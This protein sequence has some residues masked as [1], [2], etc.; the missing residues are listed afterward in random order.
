MSLRSIKQ[1]LKIKGI[2]YQLVPVWQWKI[3]DQEYAELKQEIEVSSNNKYMGVNSELSAAFLVWCS[4]TFRRVFQSSDDCAGIFK[5]EFKNLPWSWELMIPEG[6][7]HLNREPF[8][9]SDKYHTRIKAEAGITIHD[10]EVKAGELNT[11]QRFLVG[12]WQRRD[13]S[14][15]CMEQWEDRDWYGRPPPGG[16]GVGY[17]VLICR[18]LIQSI[19]DAEKADEIAT[20]ICRYLSWDPSGTPYLNLL[21]FVKQYMLKDDPQSKIPLWEPEVKRLLY[22]TGIPSLWTRIKP[23]KSFVPLEQESNA[24]TP[25]SILWVYA[26]SSF[27]HRAEFRYDRV[28][29]EWKVGAGNWSQPQYLPPTESIRIQADQFGETILSELSEDGVWLFTEEAHE[30]GVWRMRDTINQVPDHT[31]LIVAS[32]HQYEEGTKQLLSVLEQTGMQPRYLYSVEHRD[33]LQALGI[34]LKSLQNDF[35][36]IHLKQ[37]TDFD[38]YNIL[39]DGKQCRYSLGLP[40]VYGFRN[41]LEYQELDSTDNRWKPVDRSKV[42]NVVKPFVAM[43]RVK[44]LHGT[45]NE[46]RLAILPNNFQIQVE[47]GESSAKVAFSGTGE[48]APEPKETLINGWWINIPVNKNLVY[49]WGR[50][51]IRIA[52]PARHTSWIIAGVEGTA[53]KCGMSQISNV[54]LLYKLGN[55][56]YFSLELTLKKKIDSYT[57]RKLCHIHKRIDCKSGIGSNVRLSLADMVM[58]ELRSLF[59]MTGSAADNIC[60]SVERSN[61]QL[62]PA[63][64]VVWRYQQQDFDNSATQQFF[65]WNL[66]NPSVPSLFL[67]QEESGIWLSVPK[68]SL[69]QSKNVWDGKGLPRYVRTQAQPNDPC[70]KSLKYVLKGNEQFQVNQNLYELFQSGVSESEWELIIATMHA[71]RIHSIPWETSWLL[72]AIL[73]SDKILCELLSRCSLNDQDWFIQQIE[74]PHSIIGF[75]FRLL[76]LST[77]RDIANG[78]FKEKIIRVLSKINSRQNLITV[79][80]LQS[81]ID[82][83]NPLPIDASKL[84]NDVTANI[85]HQNHTQEQQE[86]YSENGDNFKFSKPEFKAW[87]G[88]PEIQ[89]DIRTQAFVWIAWFTCYSDDQTYFKYYSSAVRFLKQLEFSRSDVVENY[90]LQLQMLASSNSVNASSIISN[91]VIQDK[92]QIEQPHKEPIAST[93]EFKVPRK[94]TGSLPRSKK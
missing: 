83:H 8:S 32:R 30:K 9:N 67:N 28:Q 78:A 45:G 71:C 1:R 70:D 13:A 51:S 74:S 19:G 94:L 66:W 52:A 73:H 69:F 92:S 60:I 37:S 14:S 62:E 77:I 76:R 17:F 90:L 5:K 75:D 65:Y 20:K 23:K 12:F 80:F 48:F 64:I 84:L 44:N 36:E 24:V 41:T 68:H 79:D 18:D 85:L 2:D 38:S 21:N 91:S 6:E 35:P 86:F 72:Q 58:S 50:I 3:S 88:Y 33:C 31:P 25:G 29:S 39:V 43:F 89:K 56:D 40:K 27:G 53:A 59:A 49:N 81:V 16:V 34:T 63:Q 61:G 4:E 11:Y 55:S 57:R 42:L 10:F 82:G 87:T 46:V 47:S 54:Y 15:Y 93:Q 7:K 26:M 22:M